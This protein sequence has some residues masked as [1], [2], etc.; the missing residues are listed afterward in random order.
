MKIDKVIGK[1]VLIVVPAYNEGKTVAEVVS[2]IRRNVPSADILVVD[3]GSS[4]DTGRIARGNGA[5]TITHPY[6]LGYGAALQ[7]GYKYAFKR[8][9]NYVVQLDGDGQHEPSCIPDLLREL[10]GSSADIVIGSRFL[11][12]RSYKVPVTRMIVIRVF[13][14]IIFLLTRQKITDP[15]SGFQALNRDVARFF[16]GVV[17]PIDFP[18]AD[19]ILA[20]HRA[21]FRISEMPVIMHYN[22]AKKS[23][24]SGLKPMYYVFKMFLSICVTLLR[25]K[26]QIMR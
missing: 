18:D 10:K 3:D 22:T 16:S 26:Q 15:T 12:K 4:D 8:G 2:D 19:V 13:R 17:F 9:Y 6:N 5:L 20:L 11:D 1:K 24:H 23:M 14:S 7:T 21:G 25:K